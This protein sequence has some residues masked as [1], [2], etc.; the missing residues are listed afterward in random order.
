M[1]GKHDS[2]TPHGAAR[3]NGNVGTV[4]VH[5]TRAASGT[6]GMTNGRDDRR[7]MGVAG[8]LTA[9]DE[10]ANLATTHIATRPRRERERA[11]RERP[12]GA[13]LGPSRYGHAHGAHCIR[14]LRVRSDPRIYRT[15]PYSCVRHPR[16]VPPPAPTRRDEDAGSQVSQRTRHTAQITVSRIS[17]ATVQIAE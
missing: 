8:R 15:L 11:E 1:S 14:D 3:G 17:H 2:H 13:R 12:R 9:P 7:A 10:A 6:D 5:S 16:V 4:H